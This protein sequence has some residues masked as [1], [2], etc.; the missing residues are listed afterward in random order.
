MAAPPP[1]S[2]RKARALPHGEAELW[3]SAMR[4]VR[5]LQ[6]R[7][8][9]AAAPPDAPPEMP[10]P[11]RSAA[12][13][14]PASRPLAPLEDGRAPGLDKRTA[15]RLKR[16]RYP[17]EARLDLHGMV[18]EEAHRALTGFVAEAAARGQRCVLV[19]TGKGLRRLAEAQE[20][21]LSGDLGILRAAVPRWLGEPALRPHILA[22]T[23]AQPRHGGGG[24]LY[25][26][27]RRQ[28]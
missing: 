8:K 21:P 15:E 28:R 27:L 10:P 13:A 1:A 19:I 12:I 3:R 4:D 14:A 2:R 22:V 9:T 20:A 17:I 16:G 5:P 18:Q 23:A 26:L 7:P 11:R 6:R 25:V 24:A